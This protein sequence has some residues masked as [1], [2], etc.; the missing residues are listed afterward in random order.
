LEKGREEKAKDVNQR[1]MGKDEK[2]RARRNAVKIK[3]REKLWRDVLNRDSVNGD[4]KS[5][6]KSE[7][8]HTCKVL[9]PVK[10]VGSHNALYMPNMENN[11]IHPFIMRNAG[12]IV[13]DIPKINC[14]DPTVSDHCILFNNNNLRI[15]LQLNGTF[16]YFHTRKPTDDELQS[17]DKIFISLD[18]AQRN[19]YCT[20]FALNE[21]SML[22]YEGE[23]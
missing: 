16:S 23:M 1:K 14:D 17:C 7:E 13:N 2:A 10:A 5:F 18:S 8:K 15:P 6:I 4:T 21:E 19:P 22:D 11:L 20:S 9:F 12:V 3:K